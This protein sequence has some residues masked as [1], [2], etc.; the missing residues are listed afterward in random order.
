MNAAEMVTFVRE[1]LAEI[2]AGLPPDTF[3]TFR[4]ALGD[5]AAAG[6]DEDL[7]RR[8]AF[9]IRRALLSLPYD[10]QVREAVADQLRYASGPDFPL[11]A[12]APARELL[13]LLAAPDPPDPPEA[14]DP[15]PEGIVAGARRRLLAEPSRSAADVDPEAE[16]LIR[17]VDPDRGTR[18][19]DFQFDP[20]GGGPRPVVQYVNRLLLADRDPWGAADWWLGGNGWLGGVPA[21]LLGRVPDVMLVEVARALVEED[22]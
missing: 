6:D 19:P 17:L 3:E 9:R 16:G 7:A 13:V 12:S 21:Q 18:C 2:R 4:R 20:D 8:A 10:S 14:D 11:L 22:D 5:L 15:E 1:H